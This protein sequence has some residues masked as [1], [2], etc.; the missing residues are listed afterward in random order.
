MYTYIYISIYIYDAIIPSMQSKRY[1]MVM[2][3]A[4]CL[5]YVRGAP[6]A[7]SRVSILDLNATLS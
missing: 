2:V 1:G 6:P 5:F 7:S 4:I 3:Y